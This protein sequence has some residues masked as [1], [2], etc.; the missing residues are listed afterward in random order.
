MNPYYISG[1]QVASIVFY[2]DSGVI[3]NTGRAWLGNNKIDIIEFNEL[4]FIRKNKLNLTKSEH[5]YIKSDKTNSYD[6]SVYYDVYIYL[7]KS[8]VKI[9]YLG[10]EIAC[11]FDD[12]IHYGNF[13]NL[14][15]TFQNELDRE[16]Y[17][18][19]TKKFMQA[20]YTRTELK[21]NG[22][23]AKKFSDFME[24]NG[25]KLSS[26]YELHKKLQDNDFLNQLTD[27]IQS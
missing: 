22:V 2:D 17:E 7:P 16:K 8:N 10:E 23:K 25:F 13:F 18:H 3:V 5:F 27:I 6:N 12:K 21:D 4:E 24:K 1:S 11:N 9:N 26:T 19:K 20:Y 15:A 14:T